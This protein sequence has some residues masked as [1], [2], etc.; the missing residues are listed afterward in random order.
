MRDRIKRH[1]AWLRTL[2]MLPFSLILAAYVFVLRLGPAIIVATAAVVT[3][4]DMPLI[5]VPWYWPVLIAPIVET[6]VFQWL[7]IGVASRLTSRTAV[8]LWVSTILFSVAHYDEGILTMIIAAPAGIVLAWAF[9]VQRDK[10]VW[11]AL[12]ATALVHMW[13]NLTALAIRLVP[14]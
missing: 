1:L 2:P 9:V 11:P 13:V 4:A 7:P 3:G 6:L 10:G 14:D 12:S 5:D 8:A